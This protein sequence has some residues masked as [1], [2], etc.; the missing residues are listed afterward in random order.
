[1]PALFL[2][3]IVISFTDDMGTAVF[4]GIV[5]FLVFN[6]IQQPFFEASGDGS[7]GTAR[8]YGIDMGQDIAHKMYKIVGSNLGISSLNTA[9][10]GG[11]IIGFVVSYLYNRFNQIEL[12]AVIA[13]F[14]GKRFVPLVVIVAMIPFAFLFLL[15]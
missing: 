10:F 8:F 11:I 13:F 2:V 5:G 6:A 4:A 15:I 12:P 14:G 3:A 9:V 1:M 7:I